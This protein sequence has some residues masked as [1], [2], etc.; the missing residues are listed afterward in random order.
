M[1]AKELV[2]D[3][4]IRRLDI[5]GNLICGAN[6]NELRGLEALARIYAPVGVSSLLLSLALSLLSSYLES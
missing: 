6:G 5:S 4:C 3:R 2:L 1:L